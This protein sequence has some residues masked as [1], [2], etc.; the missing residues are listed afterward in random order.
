VLCITS[1]CG[2]EDSADA[3][4]DDA[5]SD[6]QLAAEIRASARERQAELKKQERSRTARRTTTLS[7]EGSLPAGSSELDG[8]TSAQGTGALLSAADRAS[9]AELAAQLSG[10]EGVAVAS[11]DRDGGVSS[12]G[13]LR[14]GVAWSTAK[15]PVVMAAISAGVGTRADA[16]QAITASD[17]AAADRIWRSLGGGEAAARAATGQ[18]RQ[19]GDASTQIEGR[20]LR[21]GLSAFGQTAWSLADQARFAAG[22]ACTRAGAEVLELMGQVVSG[23]RWG[24]GST[25]QPARFKAGWGPGISPG[26]ADGWLDRQFG[27][28]EID[29]RPIAVAIA[30]TAGDHDTGT[31]NV[32]AIARWAV[33]HVRA[34]SAPRRAAC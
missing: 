23:Q 24:L 25:E 21:A 1:G 31:Q 16:M 34:R 33:S 26:S 11:L 28:V 14:S 20:K 8:A 18:L 10:E 5:S 22:M 29:G 19:A 6:A 30:T 2:G 27:I 15:V 4:K 3:G 17:N 13:S 12:A 32:T 7:G 9:F